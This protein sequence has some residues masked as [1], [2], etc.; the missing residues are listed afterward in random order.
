M[1][2]MMMMMMM[3]SQLCMQVRS[4]DTFLPGYSGA[5]P[6]ALSTVRR[7]Y[8]KPVLKSFPRQT[9]RAMLLSLKRRTPNARKP[10]YLRN[11]ISRC[12]NNF[13]VDY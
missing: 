7:G 13:T 3:T 10:F 1:M 8:W 4:T 12:D 5:S 9:S 11:V 6:C 2:M